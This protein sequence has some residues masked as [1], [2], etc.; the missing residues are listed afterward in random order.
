MDEVLPPEPLALRDADDETVAAAIEDW[1]RIEA[2]V[3][4]RRLDAICLHGLDGLA[5]RT[6]TGRPR[7]FPATVLAEVKAPAKR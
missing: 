1:D 2:A 5:D 7:R 6:R 4:A 3:S